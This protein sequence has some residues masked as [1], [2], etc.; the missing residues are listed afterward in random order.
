M[1]KIRLL[2]ADD[3]AVVRGGLRSLFESDP[4]FVIVGEAADG[5]EAVR[6][7]ERH[8][9]DVA[10]LDISMPNVNGVEATRIIKKNQPD[11]QVLI[12]TIHESEEFI[13]E[14]IAAGADGYVL[15]NAEKKE[16]FDAVR[17]IARGVSFFSPN[18]SRLLLESVVRR[19]RNREPFPGPGENRLTTREL[20]VIRLIAE[21]LTSRQIA[22]KLFISVTTVNSHR[23]N[24]MKK[25]D[26]HE[27]V[28]LVKYAIARK[29]VEV[30]PAT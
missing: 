20:E 22:E 16:I 10:V 9:P 13:Q 25:L 24:M 3:H 8:R 4:Q 19:A 18:V 28:G 6:L 5:L 17:A 12:L 29:L 26:I 15:K 21:G 30:P 1:E 23:T 11:T 14:L 2:F 27:A 7:V